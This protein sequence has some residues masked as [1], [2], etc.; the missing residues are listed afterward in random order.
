MTSRVLK[1]KPSVHAVER[2]REYLGTNEVHAVSFA[3]E[4]MDDAKYVLTQDSGRL[5]YKNESHDVMIVVGPHDNSIITVLPSQK[6][7]KEIEQGSQPVE[8][9]VISNDNIFL[10]AFQTTVKRELTKARRQFVRESRKL[11]EEIAV[12][13]LEIA[14]LNLN[15]ARAR[16]PITQRQI[17]D[18]VAKIHEEQTKLAEQRKQLEAQF[19]AMKSEVSGF[20]AGTDVGV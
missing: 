15:K 2:M 1:Y 6:K 10:T 14:R 4:L 11:T 20:V 17:A 13:G 18:R 8:T 3:N 12:I 7:R 5:L 9:Q 19:R 16:S